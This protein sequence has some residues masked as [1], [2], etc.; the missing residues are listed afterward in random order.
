MSSQPARSGSRGAERRSRRYARGVTALRPWERSRRARE[1]RGARAARPHGRAE[2][3]FTLLEALVALLL[4]G[5]VALTCLRALQVMLRGQ[6]MTREHLE[7]VA[8]AER[9][10]AELALLP[11]DS[12]AVYGE[13]RG[14]VFPAP[15]EQY[16][17]RALMRGVEGSPALVRA[18]VL[19]EWPR[20]EYSLETTFY[21][22]ARG[23]AVQ[24]AAW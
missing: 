6:A 22:P 10:M 12:I 2:T 1:G 7:A 15:F 21:R 5:L 17:W 9:R 19:V 18:A 8:L 20:G 24:E 16:R 3:G 13:P 4:V 23:P 14:D 11:P